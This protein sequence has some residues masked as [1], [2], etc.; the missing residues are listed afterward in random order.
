MEKDI[1]SDFFRDVKNSNSK[2]AIRVYDKWLNLDCL[3][4]II[5]GDG[6]VFWY[7]LIG[8]T[9]GGAY[10]PNYAFQ[11]MKRWAKKRGLEYLYDKFPA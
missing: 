11:Y 2:I 7:T 5:E 1:T 8:D 10:M 9:Y 4:E 6:G 3:R